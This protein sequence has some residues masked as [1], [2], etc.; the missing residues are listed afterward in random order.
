M[1]ILGVQ[2]SFEGLTKAKSQ[3][4]PSKLICTPNI[5]IFLKF[6]TLL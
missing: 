1:Y 2:I 3:K 6:V 4:Q 5:Y